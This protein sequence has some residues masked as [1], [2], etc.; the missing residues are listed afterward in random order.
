MKTLV[1][2]LQGWMQGKEDEHLEF[3]E[4]KNNFH[5]D[6]LVKYCAA[7]A[8]EGGG[9]I[10]LGVTDKR[11]R[12]VVGSRA[13]E[14]LE[15]T[16]A[17]LVER[18]HIR[19]DA[20]EITHPQGRVLVFHVPPRP[21]GTAIQYEGAYWMRAGED[22][23]A[24]T[25]DQLK[26]IF[27]EGVADFS[28]LICSGAGLNDLDPSA[29]NE[30]RSLWRRKSGNPA[31]DTVSDEQLLHDAELVFD[32][33]VTYAAL[34]LL[35]SRRALGRFLA[36]AEVVFEYRSTEASVQH[37]S[38]QEFREGFFLFKDRLW[39]EANRRNDVQHIQEGLF[40]RDVPTFNEQVVRE[41]ILNAVSHRDYRLPGSVFI[42]QYPRRLELVSP[43]G[44]PP[45]IS[46][47]NILFRQSP[48]NRRIAEVLTKCGLVE[49][50]GQGVDK[51]FRESLL[52]GKP[53]P[54]YTGTDEYQV[55][56]TVHGDIQNPKFLRF[57]EE[58]GQEQSAAF[59]IQDLQVLDLAYRGQAIPDELKGCVPRLVEQGVLERVGRGRGTR[60]ILSR[61]FY[62]YLDEKGAYTR[63]RGLD[64]ETNKELLFRHIRD[65]RK[66]GSRFNDL[67]EVL[68]MLTRA[69][70][71][72][73][74]QELKKEEKIYIEGATRGARWYPRTD[75]KG[76]AASK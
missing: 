63:K 61:R 24:M 18:L 45:G 68:P 33:G 22:L 59:S 1:E 48:R 8:N 51:M 13:F 72:T 52:E 16:K 37:Q 32:D 2:Q 41:A 67:K 31:L 14:N 65:N 4:A 47:A 29:T 56:L 27:D 11:P 43:G 28:A 25:P 58:V 21:V 9:R 49:R 64:R 62:K 39:Q 76:I 6:T 74:L 35:G 53:R 26:R 55:V 38:R 12:K 60:Y 15:R 71:Q 57:M 5:F 3:K 70:V 66:D 75:L 50:S 34:I 42:R 19:V 44:F 46:E 17:G 40:I 69:Q 54:E 73:L 30:L 7:L 20:E 36:Q 23:V 10:V